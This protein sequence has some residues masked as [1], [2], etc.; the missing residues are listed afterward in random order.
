[1]NAT[2]PSSLADIYTKAADHIERVGWYQGDLY[3]HVQAKG[4][5]RE[6]CRVCTIGALNVALYG[7]PSYPVEALRSENGAQDV[8]S[9]FARRLGLAAAGLSIADWNDDDDRTVAQVTTALRKVAEAARKEA[10]A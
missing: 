2:I 8:E 6:E 10:A 3:D 7:K 9:F 4:T 5:P 1:M